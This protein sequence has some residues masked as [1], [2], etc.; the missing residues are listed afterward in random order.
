[1]THHRTLLPAAI[2]SALF[3]LGS[4]AVTP[5]AAADLDA[6]YLSAYG[7]V[8]P[9]EIYPFTIEYAVGPSGATTARIAV[10][11]PPSAEFDRASV[12]PSS[13]SA[14]STDP[15]VFDLGALSPDAS[16][17]IIVWARALTLAEDD[18][19][20]WKDLSAT[21]TFDHSVGG[22]P[23]PT[24]SSTTLGPKVTT[25]ETARYGIRKFPLVMVQYQDVKHCTAPGD[26]YPE[27]TGNHTAQA[28]DDAVNSRTSGSSLW[29]LYNDMS[30]GQ[31]QPEGEVRPSP[32]SGTVP[33]APGYNYK[34]STLQPGGFCTGA[35]VAGLE[36]SLVYP[37]RIE[38]G[39][40]TLPGNQGYYG[41]DSIGHGLLAFVSNGLVFGIDDGCGPTGKIAY[42]AAAIADPDLD[43]NDFDTDKDGVVDFLNVAFAG[44]GGNG[45]I[46]VTGVNNVWPHKSDLRF[47]FTDENGETGY[48]SNDQLRNHVG[49]P[50]YWTD[51]ERTEM[52][53]IDTGI[54]VWVRVGPYNVNPE[55]A[56]EAM[57][58]IAHE[59]GHSLGLPD[60]YSLGSR[61][62]FGSWE[63]MATDH[64]QFMTAFTRQELGWIVPR[65]A[66]DQVYTL[67]ESKVDTGTI[68]WETPDGM[69]YTVTGPG[70]HNADALRI[71]LPKVRLIDSV[72]SGERAWHSG[73]G[74]DF[75][76]PP[77]DGHNLTVWLPELEQYPSASD[78]SLTFQSFYE[79][80]WDWDYAFVMVSTDGG[81][82]WQTLPSENGTTMDV[83]NPHAVT[84]L[85]SNGNGITGVSGLPNS[86]ATPERYTDTYPDAVW[87][88]DSFDLT[89]FAGQKVILRLS[90]FTDTAVAKRGWF[91]DDL[92]VSVDGETIYTSDFEEEEGSK[93]F[94][95]GWVR[96]TSD[97]GNPADHAYYIEVRD[98]VGWDFDGRGQADR[99]PPTWEPGVSITYTDENHGYGNTGVDN[100]P[101]QINVDAKPDPGNDNPDLN[102]AAFTLGFG[103]DRFDSCRHIDNYDTPEG[104]WQLPTG[105]IV[106]VDDLYGLSSDG[107]TSEATARLIVDV[108]PDCSFLHQGPQLSFG[109]GHQDPDPDGSFELTWLRPTEAV[110]PDQLQEATLLTQLVDD[111]AENGT[112]QWTVATE[113]PGILP[114]STA[115]G[116][117][118]SGAFS[119]YTVA[120]DDVRS[121][122]STLTFATPL[123]IPAVGR[124]ILTFWD[125]FGGELDDQGF[126]EV[127]VDGANWDVIYQT[128]GPVFGDEAIGFA[129]E[130]LELQVLDL[131]AYAGSTIQL[132]F[133]YF[134]GQ[135]NY[136]FYTP[137]GW[138]VDDI[139]VD[140]S[141]WYD[142]TLTED[143]SFVRNGLS[144]GTYYYRVRSSYPAGAVTVPSPWSNIL[145]TAVDLDDPPAG[146]P[147]LT[148]TSLTAR[149]RKG[150]G[151]AP[152][153]V[154][155]T[156]TN[157]STTGAPA[158]K[159]QFVLD[160]S[161][162][163]FTRGIPDL[164]PG[165]SVE[166]TF[167]WQTKN[168]PDGTYTL[169]ATADSG[170]EVPEANESN[171]DLNATVTLNDGRVQ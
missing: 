145:Q 23:Q 127:S 161:T 129:E 15:L 46:S 74:N 140:T 12:E 51:Q 143:T 156:I 26:P 5:A 116:K 165:G 110:A 27:C 109:S 121:A 20:I 68:H 63:L 48:V 136:V 170:A 66:E 70:V 84:C 125:S 107:Q 122:S 24:L 69:P 2:A 166:V 168:L 4:L 148:V 113:D 28:L 103:R 95:E 133:R 104:L 99:G 56:I 92:A 164:A 62:T 11:L 42:D 19:I 154:R 162:I 98:R 135:P 83:Y 36:G 158:S 118:N 60:F 90:Y 45:S 40:Y 43:Y 3:L 31:L 41:S 80:E 87:I 73:S 134:V 16:G 49:E 78:I 144:D 58:V 34:W 25:L 82:T 163:L 112:S 132:R 35:T 139:L 157:Q 100:P 150:N 17:K 142:I 21:V 149:N 59:Y 37:N 64:A 86:V 97:A 67:Q 14:T 171:N 108:D 124:T 114:W 81:E 126:V 152:V 105:A 88:E 146:L 55:A 13:G 71:D 153:T 1:M 159:V 151:N 155:A 50:M 115:P 75:G 120:T 10:V 167:Q 39:W 76:C 79:I 52:T 65:E 33:F 6:V 57:S 8:K 29:Q 131:G 102:D 169:T 18:Q 111:D 130:P 38:D 77:Q 61:N 123:A 22:F 94:P 141:N 93:Y 47:Y 138:Y 9:G 160:G 72:P 7:W 32:G 106:Y 96:I 91:I 137:L 101:A 89:A 117:S 54:P 147:D 119:F 53:T 128:S 30:F 44:D 85:V